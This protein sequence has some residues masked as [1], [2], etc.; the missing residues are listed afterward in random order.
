MGVKNVI[1]LPLLHKSPRFK[2]NQVKNTSFPTP[3]LSSLFQLPEQIRKNFPFQPPC[4]SPRWPF[5]PSLLLC[6]KIECRN[7]EKMRCVAKNKKIWWFSSSKLSPPNSKFWYSCKYFCYT[8]IPWR[9]CLIPDWVWFQT[10]AIKQIS[11]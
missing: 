9:C 3:P 11:R 5:M 8:G 10:T 7:H 6:P 1:L 4:K 2:I